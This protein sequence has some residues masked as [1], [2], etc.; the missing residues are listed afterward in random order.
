MPRSRPAERKRRP[1]WRSP[2]RRPATQRSVGL[3]LALAAAFT[4]ALPVQASA[5]QNSDEP[6]TALVYAAG[7]A[8][9]LTDATTVGALEAGCPTYSGP[10][11]ELYQAGGIAADGQ[12]VSAQAWALGTLLSCLPTPV[13][14]GA[15]VGVTVLGAEGPELSGPPESSQLS[16][17]DLA[18]PSDF[19]DDAESPV[20]YSDG[21]GLIYDRPWRGPG[22]ANAPDQVVEAAPEPF[23][24]QVFE[25]PALSVSASASVATVAAGGTVRLTLK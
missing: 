10:N 21:S 11:I 9:P 12:Q 4:V 3:M 23:V 8:A 13:P 25:G 18:S 20:L 6:V 7:N 17:A 22:D 5:D 14:L 16:P 19:A 24:I 1:G 2:I 15:V